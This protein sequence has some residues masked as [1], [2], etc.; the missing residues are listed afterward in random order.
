MIPTIFAYLENGK[1]LM[2]S[3]KK[4]EKVRFSE[5]QNMFGDQYKCIVVPAA[6]IVPME[7][8][9]FIV[10]FFDV[11]YFHSNLGYYVLMNLSMNPQL[12]NNSL[13]L[14]SYFHMM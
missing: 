6:I 14:D 5:P 4:N 12:F 1:C 10:N 8:L 7:T 13:I 9:D 11:N 3:I 2:H